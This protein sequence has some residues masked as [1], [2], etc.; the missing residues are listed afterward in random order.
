[1]IA[2][3]APKKYLPDVYTLV[4]LASSRMYVPGQ[5]EK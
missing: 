3:S 2:A 4:L 5:G 1:M